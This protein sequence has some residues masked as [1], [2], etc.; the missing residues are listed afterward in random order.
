MH[1]IWQ[2]FNLSS[3][4]WKVINTQQVI[5]NNIKLLVLILK[6]EML[7]HCEFYSQKYWIHFFKFLYQ[8]RNVE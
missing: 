7:Y 8:P 1:K 4:V 2:I 6:S 3:I 5:N